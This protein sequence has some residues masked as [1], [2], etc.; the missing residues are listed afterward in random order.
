MT[1]RVCCDWPWSCIYFN[2]VGNG[3]VW[4]QEARGSLT[5]I[6]LTSPPMMVVVTVMSLASLTS[7][8]MVV[9]VVAVTVMS[10]V[11]VMAAPRRVVHNLCGWRRGINDC[12][13]TCVV[14]DRGRGGIGHRGTVVHRWRWR[15][16]VGLGGRWGRVVRLRRGC[17]GGVVGRGAGRSGAWVAHLLLRP[18]RVVALEPQGDLD[19]AMLVPFPHDRH[20]DHIAPIGSGPV[21]MNVRVRGHPWGRLKRSHGGG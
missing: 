18:H 1:E 6:S 19:K 5:S 14:H 4:S 20:F 21:R 7:P 13:G 12:G 9:V 8:P 11:S 10:M 2:L 17:W 15:S 3:C 16:V